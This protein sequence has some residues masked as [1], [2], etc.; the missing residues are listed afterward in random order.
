MSNIKWPKWIQAIIDFFSGGV[1]PEPDKPGTVMWPNYYAPDFLQHGNG[2]ENAYRNAAIVGAS[3]TGCIRFN[4]RYG[5][6]G[7]LQIH[8]LGQEYQ[9]GPN[10]PPFGWF[11]KAQNQGVTKWVHDMGNCSL[12]QAREWIESNKAAMNK[13]RLQ[14][15]IPPGVAQDVVDVLLAEA[16]RNGVEVVQV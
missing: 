4:V 2:N 6:G 13:G 14:Y 11:Q 15:H 8:I 12:A 9:G 16:K 7:D 10:P 5:M 3:M 1:T